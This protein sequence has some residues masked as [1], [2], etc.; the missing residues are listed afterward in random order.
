MKTI[1]K[2]SEMLSAKSCRLSSDQAV[3][4]NL[5][6]QAVTTNLIQQAR[7]T[8]LSQKQNQ[9]IRPSVNLL[10]IRR[11]M[12]GTRGWLRWLRKNL[13]L[14]VTIY[15]KRSKQSRMHLMPICVISRTKSV[16]KAS[17][18]NKKYQKRKQRKYIEY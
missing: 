18:N 14:I 9:R 7:K 10:K 15:L 17:S 2:Q 8:N 12:A 3:T 4:M 16:L 11:S 13:K 1:S 6:Q 5:S